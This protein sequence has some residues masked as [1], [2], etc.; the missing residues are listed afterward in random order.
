MIHNT[1]VNVIREGVTTI[2]LPGQA[3]A[4][5]MISTGLVPVQ[6]IQGIQGI[7]G[8]R[9]PS[10]LAD[11][12]VVFVAPQEGDLLGVEGGVITNIPSADLNLNGG[13]F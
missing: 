4:V 11:M 6:G 13:Y 12:E 5:T 8:P 7:Q 1:I 2:Q 9:G 10:G 3:T